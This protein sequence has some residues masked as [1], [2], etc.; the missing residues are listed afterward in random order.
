MG[1]KDLKSFNLA[2]L[3][4]Q[5]WKILQENESLIYRCFK[6]KYF[7]RCNFLE[8]SEVPNSSF[9]LKSIMAAQPILRKGCC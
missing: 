3:A 8:A 6:S 1:F 7:P 4:K 5:G 9:V 2:M